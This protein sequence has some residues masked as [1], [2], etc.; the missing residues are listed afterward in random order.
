M[1]FFKE[2]LMFVIE[3]FN[4][5]KLIISKIILDLISTTEFQIKKNTTE[6]KSI[7]DMMRCEFQ[8]TI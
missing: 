4:I 7:R 6:L 1:F 3:Y 2:I 5:F 8:P